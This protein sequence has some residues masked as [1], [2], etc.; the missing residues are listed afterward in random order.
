MTSPDDGVVMSHIGRRI[1]KRLKRFCEQLREKGAVSELNRITP[2]N[3][4][5]LRLAKCFP[6]PQERPEEELFE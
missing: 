2:P 1:V 3:A 4:E 6:A 5:L